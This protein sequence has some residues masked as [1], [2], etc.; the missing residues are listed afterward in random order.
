MPNRRKKSFRDHRKR[1]IASGKI[2]RLERGE[3]L[4]KASST[5]ED[6]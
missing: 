5:K 4:P 3:K 1:Q 6:K 2:T